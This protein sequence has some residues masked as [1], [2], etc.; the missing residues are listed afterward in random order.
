MT[1]GSQTLGASG[2]IWS[3][4][5]NSTR[6]TLPSGTSHGAAIVTTL[7]IVSGVVTEG[8]TV[9]RIT[10]WPPSPPARS[11]TDQAKSGAPATGVIYAPVDW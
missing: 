8:S 10:I 6:A 11:A 9:P 7:V 4:T 5:R 2:T 1:S 3:T